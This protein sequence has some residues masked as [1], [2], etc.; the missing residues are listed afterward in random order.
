M[1]I[2]LSGDCTVDKAEEIAARLREAVASGGPLVLHLER[3]SQADLSFF[4]LLLALAASCRERG[5][6]LEVAGALPPELEDR[7]AW[8]DFMACVHID[9]GGEGR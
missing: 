6:A 7:A 8:V 4:Q 1:D 2:E 5:L 9:A 3:V